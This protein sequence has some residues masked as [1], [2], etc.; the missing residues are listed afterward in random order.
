MHSLNEMYVRLLADVQRISGIPMGSPNVSDE[1][2]LVEAPK[3]DK[4]MLAYFEGIGEI[5]IFP[6]WLAPLWSAAQVRPD[7]YLR[8]LRT[9]LL[10]GYK[11]EYVP[12]QQQL[13]I[14]ESGFLD[15]ED[16][17]RVW[18]SSHDESSDPFYRRVRSLI[19]RVLS[20]CTVDRFDVAL[21]CHGPGA[22]KPAY[23]PWMKGDFSTDYISIR[24]FYTWDFFQGIFIDEPDCGSIVEG[25]DIVCSLTA[26]PKDSRGP[27]LICVHPKEAIWVQQSQRTVVE[28]AIA[29]SPLTNGFIVIDDQEVNGNLALAAS[30]DRSFCTLDLKEASDRLGFRLVN[31]LLGSFGDRLSCARATHVKLL[32]GRT[33]PL[34]KWAPMGNCLTFPIQSLVFWAMVQTAI[35]T[36]TGRYGSVY[37]YGDDIIFPSDMYDQVIKRLV[38][39]GLVPNRNKTFVRGSFR[40]SCGIDA[41]N[42]HLVTPLRT[43]VGQC[44]SY[45]DAVSLCS[46]ARRA[47]GLGYS[48]LADYAY[49][50]V[51]GFLRSKGQALPISNNEDCQGIFE[52]KAVSLDRMISEYAYLDDGSPNIR[53][54]YNYHRFESRVLLQKPLLKRA[55]H[56]RWNV[57][58]SLLKLA[59]ANPQETGGLVYADP[60]RSR[61]ELGWIELRK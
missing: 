47:A 34:L 43:K 24:A 36:H 7:L 29:S 8:M 37:V 13:E 20:K 25:N 42:G 33:V 30:I 14:A 32:S 38:S 18:N 27:R 60:S 58:D 5:P 54:N 21:P 41:F 59:K 19:H 31:Y 1:W 56:S 39:A 12:T 23:K 61:P 48:S 44:H 35:V 45:T 26:V 16:G 10:F 46:L 53:W 51:R 6:D 11:A 57:V 2:V 3:L 52:Y 22:V 4:T 50:L 55:S 17:I 49:E 15:A 28:H 9:V 40:E